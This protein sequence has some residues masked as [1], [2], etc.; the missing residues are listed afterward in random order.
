[1]YGPRQRSWGTGVANVTLYDAK[2]RYR[3]WTGG[4]FRVHTT[5]N[6]AEADRDLFLL[7]GL[8]AASFV[9]APALDWERI[10]DPWRADVL[11]ADGWHS[12]DELL[13]ALEVTTGYALVRA[14]DLL[15]TGD[16]RWAGDLIGAEPRQRLRLIDDG[17]LDHRWQR[18]ILREAASDDRGFLVA[19]PEHR[20]H[21][22]LAQSLDGA[23]LVR[24]AELPALAAEAG[25]PDGPY[26]DPIFARAVLDD[27]L[28]R[29]GWGTVQPRRRVVR[30]ARGIAARLLR[31]RR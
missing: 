14:P 26:G 12:P 20:F 23:T 18:A 31:R 28:Q 6:R 4:G 7:L 5:I 10:P 16:A 13:T 24:P 15:L 9:Q 27:F 30:A 1:V 17:L 22:L 8:R 3:E 29:N 2:Y 25:A 11:G 19:T 21:A